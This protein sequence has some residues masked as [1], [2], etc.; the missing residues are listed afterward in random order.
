MAYYLTENFSSGVD[1]RKHPLT[2]P[3]GTLRELVNAHINP[4]GEIEKRQSFVKV[5]DLPAIARRGIMR[6]GD[7]VWFITDTPDP[8]DALDTEYGTLKIRYISGPPVNDDIFL[9]DWDL[10]DG[11]LYF[12][13]RDRTA[14]DL[15]HWYQDSPSSNTATAVPEGQ[16]RYIRTYKSKMYSCSGKN[17]YFSAVG[18]PTIW[19]TANTEGVGQGFINAAI[20]DAEAVDL[21]GIEVYYDDLAFFSTRAVQIWRMDTDPANNQQI[22]TIRSIGIAGRATPRQYGSGDILF[23]SLSGIRSLQARDSSNSASV[24]DVGSPIDEPITRLIREQTS[25]T[26]VSTRTMLEDLTGRFWLTFEDEAWVLSIFPG[27]KVTAWSKYDPLDNTG[28]RFDIEGLVDANGFVCVLGRTSAN[29]YSAA[30]YVLGGD[31]RDVYDS[32]ETVVQTPYIGFD[33]PGNWKQ[34]LGFDTAVDET[35]KVEMSLDP[36]N[37]VWEEVGTI[38]KSTYNDQ[39]LAFN[40]YSPACSIRMTSTSAA[41]ARVANLALHYNLS[42]AD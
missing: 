15:T 27:P 42:K 24:T 10:F 17:I 28:D 37:V 7:T 1:T 41:R 6:S 4:G 5:L 31:T 25:R 36:D 22:Q 12:V 16:G 2:A 39:R 40:G 38:T 20:N 14:G 21:Q 30:L 19:D 11:R 3:P 18:D 34:F 13:I 26:L 32:V 33:R 9:E 23:L 29:P 8:V 35:W